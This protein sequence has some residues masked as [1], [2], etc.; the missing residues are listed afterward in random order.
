MRRQ[1]CLEAGAEPVG[2]P[3]LSQ[4]LGWWGPGPS[5][6]AGETGRRGE[7]GSGRCG[8]AAVSCGS[9]LH[10]YS[11][12]ASQLT[13]PA[14]GGPALWKPQL[15]G[16]W[17]PAW[18]LSCEGGS[19]VSQDGEPQPQPPASCLPWSLLESG[20]K[21]EGPARILRAP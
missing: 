1:L 13:V 21:Q 9:P 5:R 2:R 4:R 15:W 20:W 17:V 10:I 7:A 12:S 6:E 14:V 19:E 18:V 16:S 11:S 3:G 8:A